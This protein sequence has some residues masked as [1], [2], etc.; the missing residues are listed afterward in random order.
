MEERGKT[1][2]NIAIVLLLAVIVWRVPGGDTASQT[3]SNLLTVILFGGLLFFGYRTYMEHRTTIMDLDN[4]LRNV[5]Y[6]SVGMITFALVATSRLWDEGG[7]WPLL[8]F[9]LIGAAVYGFVTV[10]RAHREY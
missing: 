2:R 3:I 10:F 6:A 7:P 5:L 8:W 4:R 1:A 9:A